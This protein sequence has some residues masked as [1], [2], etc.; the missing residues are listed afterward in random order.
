M[1]IAA[2]KQAGYHFELRGGTSLSKCLRITDRFSDDID[3]RINPPD[4]M[5]VATG[6]NQDKPR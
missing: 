4:D 1:R 2:Q 6:R 3:L 5:T